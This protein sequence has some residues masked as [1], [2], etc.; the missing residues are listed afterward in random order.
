M[1][2][3]KELYKL[4]DMIFQTMEGLYQAYDYKQKDKYKIALA[5]LEILNEEYKQLTGKLFIEQTR[6][7]G[8]YTKM[9]EF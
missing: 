4:E 8:Y 3:V 1:G 7:T 6:I 2:K 9:W 5:S